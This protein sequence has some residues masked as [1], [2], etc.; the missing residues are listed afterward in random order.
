MKVFLQSVV[1]PLHPVAFEFE[2]VD[3]PAGEYDAI[4]R[5]LSFPKTFLL[6]EGMRLAVVV[7]ASV[8]HQEVDCALRVAG[9]D[10]AVGDG[11]PRQV[12]CQR[13][14]AAR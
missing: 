2:R 7:P 5:D 12:H 9:R 8:L 14:V 10:L 1:I 13:R 3:F 11:N 4:Q 6:V